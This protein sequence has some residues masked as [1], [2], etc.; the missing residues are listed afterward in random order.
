MAKPSEEKLKV[1]Y[2]TRK[3]TIK[4]FELILKR[5]EP[6]P[7]NEEKLRTLQMGSPAYVITL[8][9]VLGFLDESSKLNSSAEELRGTPEDFKKCLEKKV[10]EIYNDLFN[11]VRDAL[12]KQEETK[13]R[14]YFRTHFKGIK[15]SM[16]TMITN[17][18]LALRDI[19]NSQGDFELLTS[20]ET[21]SGAKESDAAKQEKRKRILDNIDEK[22]FGKFDT[23]N[24]KLTL[25]LNI[26]L[27]V[28]TSR[29]AIEE[30]F[31]NIS[32]AHGTVFGE[33]K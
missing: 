9:K 32:L 13:V 26:N 21:K 11:T 27:D 2:A 31:K 3:D 25:N 16:L 22:T 29:E 6:T 5:K 24:L 28:G 20:K 30:L 15:S 4:I 33:N 17:C 18:F 14:D 19:I 23:K 8:L 10:R 12:N 1:P 7:I